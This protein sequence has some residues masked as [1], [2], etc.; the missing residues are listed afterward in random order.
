M[1][2]GEYYKG[3]LLCETDRPIHDASES[4]PVT[5]RL[6]ITLSKKK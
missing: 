2:P 1:V 5:V 4:F 3:E 6:E